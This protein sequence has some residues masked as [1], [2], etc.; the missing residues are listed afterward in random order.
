VSRRLSSP[1]LVGRTRETARLDDALAGAEEGRGGLV[2]VGG[3][4]GIGKS[5]LVAELAD[6]ARVRGATV[7]V[8]GC[9]AMG[10]GGIPYAPLAQAVR[11]WRREHDRGAGPDGRLPAELAALVPGLTLGLGGVGPTAAPGRVLEAVLTFFEQL[12]DDAP[13]VLVLEDVHW[14]DG[15]TRDLLALLVRMLSSERVLIVATYRTDELHRRHPLRAL[16][17]DL[18]RLPETERIDLEPLTESDLAQQIEGIRSAPATPEELGDLWRRSEGNPF[19]AEE[20]V[21]CGDLGHLPSSLRDVLLAKVSTLGD[22]EQAVLRTAAGI[23][24]SVD[25]RLLARVVDLPRADLDLA[26][27]ALADASLLLLDPPDGYAFRH[28]LLQEVV[29]DELLPGERVALHVRIAEVLAADPDLQDGLDRACCSGRG[30]AAL[31]HHWLEARRLPEAL[32]AS[33]AAGV[34][35]ERVGAPA[36]ALV[37]Y[38]QALE[39]WPSVP[40]ADE[41]SPLGLV[42]VVNRAATAADLSGR[43]DRALALGEQAISLV[44]PVTD[45]VRAALAHERLGRFLWTADREGLPAYEEA[46][47]LV[48][49][50]PAGPEQARVLAGYGQMLM[51]AGEVTRACEVCEEALAVALAVG[52]RQVEGHAR[53]TLGTALAVTTDPERGLDELRTARA[54]AEELGDPDDIGRAYVNLTDSLAKQG[55]WDESVEVGRAGVVACQRLG[56]DRTYGVYVAW[57]MQE[58]LVARGRWDEVLELEAQVAARLPTGYWQYVL[59]SPMRADRGDLEGI[60]RILTDIGSLP[61]GSAALQALDAW[62]CAWLA[63]LTWEGRPR[64]AR[65]IVAETVARIP[66]DYICGTLEMLWRALWAEA[67]VAAAARARRDATAEAEAIAVG[68]QLRASHWLWVRLDQAPNARV[69]AEV[70]LCDAETNRISGSDTASDWQVAAAAADD[71]GMLFPGAYARYRAAEALVRAGDR[72]GAGAELGPAVEV[73]RRLGARPLQQLGEQLAARARLVLD[74]AVGGAVAGPQGHAGPELFGLSARE[75]E[76]LGLVATGR[77]NRQVAEVLY[78][79]PKTA[80]VHVS[81]IL[82]KLGVSSRVEA[83]GVAHRL[84]LVDAP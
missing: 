8:G 43:F 32:V 64:E 60:R 27:R 30:A 13:V 15:S 63:L 41:R 80:S 66:N 7:L 9:V 40:D 70:A 44:D 74:G 47:R 6:R 5:R 78:I 1:T 83:A 53:N 56:I 65:E 54:I 34:E 22:R 46:V 49:T 42:D 59:A 77:T 79:S 68:E 69:A 18:E 75:L 23:G 38:E 62:G 17:A 61:P 4:A 31:A 50:E 51:L 39:L 19:F 82:A 20:L 37:Q 12:A 10:D 52:A 71:A 36:D 28:A 33:V 2:L 72:A 81:N 21:A 25:D 35:A 67:D 55:R 3:E 48:S 76:V 58:G 29:Y 16:V 11:G 57:N 45:P 84:G 26:L 73:A 14:A 24:P